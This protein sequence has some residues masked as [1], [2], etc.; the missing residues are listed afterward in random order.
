MSKENVSSK[1]GFEAAAELLWRTEIVTK[2]CEN[3]K[4]KRTCY[5][6]FLT[7]KTVVQT[8]NA[9]EKIRQCKIRIKSFERELNESLRS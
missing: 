4:R 1:D 7:F 8:E 3:C 6:S 2:C 9:I 5:S